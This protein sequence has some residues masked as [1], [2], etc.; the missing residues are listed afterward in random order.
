MDD[1]TGVVHTAPAFGQDDYNLGMKYGL[2]V[3]QPVD[4]AGKFTDVVTDWAGEFVK[5]ADKSIIRNLKDR[6]LL[7]KRMQIMHSYPFCWRC[8]SPLI[9]YARSSW[10]I[11][12]S[13]FKEQM[14]RNNEKIN[15][16]PS[17]VGEKRFG[18]WLKNNID[19]AISRDRFWGTPLNIWVCDDCEERTSV[20][21]IQE[22]RERGV[23]ENGEKVPKDI[24]LHRPYIDGVELKCS[25]GGKM[26][27]TP[28][29]IDC[30]FDS[31]A[32]PFAQWHY[33]FENEEIFDELYP[34][35]FICEGIDQTRGWF[36]TL[37]AISTI[38]RDEAPY[39]NV[40]VNDLILDKKGLKMSKSRGNSVSGKDL[41]NLFDKYGADAVRTYLLAVSPPWVPTK[42][43]EKG[44]SEIVS[45]FIGTLKNVYSFYVTY[46][47]IDKFDA[48]AYENSDIK[49]AEIDQWIISRLNTLIEEVTKNFNNYDLTRSVRQIQTFVLDDL[50]NWY[51]RRCRRR[52]WALTL[53]DD[54]RDAY[55]TL[56][57]IL[58]ATAQ[59]M[60]PFAPFLSEEI[61]TNLT[62]GR[63][64]HL[65]DFPKVNKEAIKPELEKEMKT[66]IDVVSLGRAARNTCQIKVR[67]TLQ[68][69]HI[70]EKAKSATERM[71]ELIQEEINV[72]DICYIADKDDFV[73][74]QIKPNFKTLGPKAGKHM[75]QVAATLNSMNPSA[76]MEA[77]KKNEPYYL[78]VE[79]SSIN[80]EEADLLIK[81]ENRD[82]FVFENNKDVF[83]ALDTKLT[84]ELIK[85]GF[86]REIVNKVQFTRKEKDFDV[87]DR[88]KVFYVADDEI[89]AVFDA[90]KEYI[91]NETLTNEIFRIEHP[92]ADMKEWD[93][94]GKPVHFSIEKSDK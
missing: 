44:V 69:L 53:T 8:K 13:Q 61:F 62:N 28:E 14:I 93:V 51:V 49:T 84:P 64:V 66:V 32:M 7:Y 91:C 12:T 65:T 17:F 47:N 60:A 86:A 81:I 21:S 82:G 87:M 26:H 57:K 55:L 80:I 20:G 40:L 22:L 90:Y 33:P 1:G 25:C 24:E 58:T 59:L 79:G 67:Q 16:N 77:F 10:Y 54:K 34:A 36:Y 45:K 38:L 63:S 78:E 73:K 42:F 68:A 75:K 89:E 2:P 85:E 11:K 94:N 88:I 5:D 29:V 37:L 92:K 4:G 72:K 52:F 31:G 30:W 35:D 70:P 39:K 19:W 46:A 71:E 6:G 43:D 15:W 3:V 56:H 48:S 27:R 50:S 83:V 18:E 23:L 41:M 74:Y 9:Y 76:M